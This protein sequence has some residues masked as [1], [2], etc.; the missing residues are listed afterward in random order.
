MESAKRKR[1]EF[2]KITNKNYETLQDFSVVQFSTAK[3]IHKL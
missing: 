3:V 2:Q 1:K